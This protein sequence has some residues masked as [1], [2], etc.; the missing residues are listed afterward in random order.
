MSMMVLAK[1][2]RLAGMDQIHIGTVIGKMEGGKEIIGIAEWLG[3][4]FHGLNTT[5]PVCSGGLHPGHVPRLTKML[6]KDIIIQAGGGIHGHKMGTKHGA[7]AMRQAV[8][9]VMEGI[10]IKDYTKDHEEL[11][12]ALKQWKT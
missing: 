9:S 7:I 3:G 6:G 4:D 10:P 1:L 11:G 5:F 12:I 8:D 2:A